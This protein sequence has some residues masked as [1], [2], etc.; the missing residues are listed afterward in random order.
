[1][2][3]CISGLSNWLLSIDGDLHVT[4]GD[5]VTDGLINFCTAALFVLN[6]LDYYNFSDCD[7]LDSVNLVAVNSKKISEDLKEESLHTNR[8]VCGY[9]M[10]HF[11]FFVHTDKVLSVHILDAVLVYF[12]GSR[13]GFNFAANFDSTFKLARMLVSQGLLIFHYRFNLLKR[14]VDGY[15]FI[16]VYR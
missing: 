9:V 11:I 15:W 8:F 14:E 16:H 13:S 4:A 12:A 2:D 3:R 7:F 1:M 5:S 10:D 6:I